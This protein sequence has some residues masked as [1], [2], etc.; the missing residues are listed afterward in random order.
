MK[1]FHIAFAVFV[2]CTGCTIDEVVECQTGISK[3]DD[4]SNFRVCESNH[5][6]VRVCEKGCLV[7]SDFVG[8]VEDASTSIIQDPTNTSCSNCIYGCLD[9]LNI[10]KCSD[11]CP[12][13][14]NSDG[15]CKTSAVAC[16]AGCK[17]DCGQDEQCILCPDGCNEECRAGDKCNITY[18]MR[19]SPN[20]IH[21]SSYETSLLPILFYA[22]DVIQPSRQVLAVSENPDCLFI[23]DEQ[24]IRNNKT[25]ISLSSG[26]QKCETKLTI[27]S[28]DSRYPTISAVVNVLPDLPDANSNHMKDTYETVPQSSCKTHS[29]CDSNPGKGDGFCDS[30]LGYKC[31]TKCTSDFEC[32]QS[33][34][35][36]TYICRP[37]G[38]CAPE[39]FET[40]WS[41]SS[42]SKTVVIPMVYANTL[43]GVFNA[44]DPIPSE[45][46]FTID[47]GDNI[48]E[49][50]TSC[51]N[52]NLTHTYTT[53]SSNVIIKIKGT[54]DGFSLT[55]DPTQTTTTNT[56]LKKI[57]TFGPV[58]LA[59]YGAFASSSRLEMSKID[60]PDATKMPSLAMAFQNAD[61]Y[62]VVLNNWDTTYVKNMS[63]TFNMSRDISSSIQNWNT[64]NVTDMS[65][66]FAQ[67]N[68][69]N[70]DLN[71]WDTSKVKNMAHMFEQTTYNQNLSN[72]NTSNVT[73]MSYMFAQNK[74]FNQDLSSW[75][76]ENV[77]DM[78]AM[79]KNAT[80]FDLDI[81]S[82]NTANVTNMAHM[83]EQTKFNQNLD[84]WNTSNVTDMSF[85]FV[86]NNTFN[87][88]LNNWNTGKVTNMNAMFQN[89][90]QF[91][92][93][94]SAWN[95]ENVTDMS[96]MFHSASL[97]NQDI[98]TWNTENVTN[99]S[100]MFYS[101]SQFNQDINAWNTENVT[102]MSYMFYSANQFN[103]NIG[104]WDTSNVTN[105]N[106]MFGYASQFNQD[107]SGW[108]TAN[109]T[110][111]SSMFYYASQFNQDLSIWDL[112]G[113]TNASNIRGIFSSSGLFCE[114]FNKLIGIGKWTEFQSDLGI[115]SSSCKR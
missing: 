65:Y 82:W 95:T 20:V 35:D 13:T 72:W 46:H 40:Q 62:N 101:A 1:R 49:K 107:I 96:Y 109:V 61:L 76:T 31:S 17:S 21:M 115:S 67:N 28:I 14:C 23:E 39:S 27:S 32:I 64:S 25:W 80:K 83:F 104:G 50:Y 60:I 89:A 22:N 74:S 73:D 66:M 79:F 75:N 54:L 69:F 113:I 84:N 81:N 7:S 5:W 34:N 103:Q 10:C 48:T 108:N 4:E 87:Q 33:D 44:G 71:D 68:S 97:F 53:S 2:V 78:S 15:S 91:N 47:W 106:Y 9:D 52:E 88:N 29:D 100:Y 98:S 105:M 112:S 77:T 56:S 51:P 11:K 114:N 86:Q 92:Q 19:I 94:I 111:M 12:D 8:C 16:P 42:S 24:I 26:S 99:M 57:I 90:R 30:F 37:D 55:D 102:D 36:Y 6:T 63:K 3:C 38:R 59:S 18:K 70:Q 43:D 85:M 93:D 41:L 45:C 58:G 110:N